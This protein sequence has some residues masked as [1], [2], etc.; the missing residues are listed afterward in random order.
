MR[1]TWDVVTIGMES[2]E[3]MQCIRH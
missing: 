2:L 3:Q 1:A